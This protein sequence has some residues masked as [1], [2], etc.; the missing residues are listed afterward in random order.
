[1]LA[2]F[3]LLIALNGN[4]EY[5]ANFVDCAHAF[6]YAARH[7]PKNDWSC[8]HENHIYLPKDLVERYY[9]PDSTD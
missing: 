2:E 3:V 7:Y 9:Y 5:V 6:E 4:K 1:M 8:L